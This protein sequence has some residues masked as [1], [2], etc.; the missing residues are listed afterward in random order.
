MRW[1]RCPTLGSTNTRTTVRVR[2]SLSSLASSPPCSL[3]SSLASSL[4]ISL[5]CSLPISL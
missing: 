3:A 2:D 4:H 1:W 5:T